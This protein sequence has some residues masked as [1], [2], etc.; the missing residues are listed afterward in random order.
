MTSV[1]AVEM[2]SPIR[3]ELMRVFCSGIREAVTIR[4]EAWV[5]AVEMASRVRYGAS[6]FL[7]IHIQPLDHGMCRGAGSF[8]WSAASVFHEF[9]FFWLKSADEDLG[10]VLP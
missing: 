8:D 3:Y 5:D 4:V 1:D 7:Q 2:A 10:R 9:G 6:R